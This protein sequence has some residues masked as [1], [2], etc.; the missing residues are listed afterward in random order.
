MEH[1][2]KS[3]P[4]RLFVSQ[5]GQIFIFFWSAT[6]LFNDKAWVTA[7]GVSLTHQIFII[8]LLFFD[9]RF[10]GSLVTRVSPNTGL[11]IP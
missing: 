10:T 5:V 3:Y 6:C 8:T 2:K 9:P 4:L 1:G 11:S 7:A